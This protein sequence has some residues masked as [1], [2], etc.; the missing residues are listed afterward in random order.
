MGFARK[1]MNIRTNLA[2]ASSKKQRK[3]QSSKKIW[4]IQGR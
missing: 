3:E 4:V 1:M 2:L